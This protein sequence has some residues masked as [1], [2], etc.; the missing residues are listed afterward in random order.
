MRQL[1]RARGSRDQAGLAAVVSI[2]L[3][4]WRRKDPR[5]GR[6]RK[7]AWKMSDEDAKRW[8]IREEAQI[9][10]IPNSEEVRTAVSGY[11]AVFFP[12]QSTDAIE[13]HF[14]DLGAKREDDK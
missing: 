2:T 10:K 6:W 14:T 5:T 4:S 12:A 1:R 9:E 11:G 7:L 8:A 13:Q 3:Y